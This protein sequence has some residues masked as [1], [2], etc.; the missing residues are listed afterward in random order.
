M[1][2]PAAFVVDASIVVRVL[3]GG[4]FEDAC[5]A[6]LDRCVT[7][8]TRLLAPTCL[9]SEVANA[10]YHLCLAKPP[11]PVLQMSEAIGIGRQGED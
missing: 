10:L 9:Y 4:P 7:Q 11:L 1:P 8:D 5:Q 3:V 2:N 6:F